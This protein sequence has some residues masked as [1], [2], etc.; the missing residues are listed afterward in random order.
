MFLDEEG[1]F[2]TQ[3]RWGPSHKHGLCPLF[4]IAGGLS[5]GGGRRFGF[6]G[7]WGLGLK[8]LGLKGLGLGFR[9]WVFRVL[10]FSRFRI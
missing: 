4:V 10:G 9:V 6:W 5:K 7:L 8:G 1:I 2:H 3:A